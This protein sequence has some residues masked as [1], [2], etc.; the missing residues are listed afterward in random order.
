MSAEIVCIKYNENNIPYI[1]LGEHEIRLESE[2]PNEAVLEKAKTELREIPEIV[3]PA[4]LELRE[5]LQSKQNRFT[6]FFFCTNIISN[7]LII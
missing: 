1:G 3:T 5:L 2:S 4:I 6:P 7:W